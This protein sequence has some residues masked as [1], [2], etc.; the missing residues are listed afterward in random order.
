MRNF[1]RIAAASAAVLATLSF[2]SA[3][4]AA[5]T[6]SA[7]AT[8]TV[9]STLSVTKTRDL[10][11]G[12][13]AVNGNGNIVLAADGTGTCPAAIICT[14]PRASAA[15]QVNGTA[16]VGVTANVTQTSINLVHATD[17]TKIFQLDG[18]TVDFPAGSTLTSGSTTF[19]VGGTLH[20]TTA[21]A[22]AGT[23]TGTFNVNVEYQ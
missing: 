1:N 15:F 8:A 9:L 12:Q 16:G 18:F 21:A 22:L 17:T 3:A 19:N 11:F 6:A 23:Y 20:V 4:Q 5:G 14:G 7:T 10:Q 2:G 13:I